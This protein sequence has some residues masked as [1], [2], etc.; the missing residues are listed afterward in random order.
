MKHIFFSVALLLGS[1]LSQAQP[2][3]QVTPTYQNI[4]DKLLSSDSK[5]TIGGYGE[6][7]YHQPFD[8][9]LRQN[10]ELD[11]HRMVML[12]GYQFNER[13]SFITELEF[14]HV[15]EVYVEQAFLQHKISKGINFRAGLLLIPMGIVNEYH[16]PTTFNGV[17][18]PLVDNRITPTT[19]R[20]VGF[21]LSG[22]IQP[23]SLKY[24][25]YLVNGF[26]G[27]DGTARLNG[28]NG[29]RSGRQRGASSYISAPNL[30][31]KVE[32][33]G[34]RGLNIG[35]S[36]YFGDTQSRLYNGIAKDDDA[37]LAKADSSVVGITMFGADAR[38]TLKGLQLRGQVYRVGLS[39]SDQYNRFTRTAAGVLNDLGSV[40]TGYYV[41]AGYNVF[42]AFENINTE[43]VPFVRI[44]GL[45]THAEVENNINRVASYKTSVIT[46]GLTFRLA[47]GAVLKS[48]LQFVKPEGAAKATKVFSAGLGVMF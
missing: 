3:D 45:D 4:A 42:R 47:Q 32:Y 29:L 36:G 33:Y 1:F 43:L 26:N 34:I 10:G 46:T 24:Q 12:F 19:W 8:S 37:A 21:G 20:E 41:E 7:H 9:D 38:Y 16:E 6:V 13:T 44:E 22:T 11:V 30:T 14:E 18:R 27:Y 31:A 25:A 48:D 40:M 15:S 35:L 5:L 39:N 2:Q 17:E 28:R 23:A